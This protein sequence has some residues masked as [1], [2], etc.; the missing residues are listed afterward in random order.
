[1]GEV[2]QWPLDRPP[3]LDV[4][5]PD[6]RSA[7]ERAREVWYERRRKPTDAAL[8]LID[9]LAPEAVQKEQQHE[10]SILWKRM[11]RRYQQFTTRPAG[12]GEA[13]A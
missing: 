13:Q 8:P 3:I 9:E 2:V 4:D 5:F 12:G 11:L 6:D 7:G 10:R 1:M